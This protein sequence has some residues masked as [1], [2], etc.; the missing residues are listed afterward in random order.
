ME[1][2]SLKAVILSGGSGTRL[3]PITYSVPK[4]LIPVGLRPVLGHVLA[5]VAASGIEEAIVIVSP[6][7][8]DHVSGLL[9]RDDHGLE[10]TIVVQEEPNGLAAA[11]A[12]ALPLIGDS[13]SLLYLGDCLVT[14]GASNLVAQHR[15]GGA[16]ATLMV[17]SVDDPSRYGI[18]EIDTEGDIT[19]LV[20][21]PHDPPSDLA[22]VG[23]YAFSP[24]IA[25]AVRS[26]TPSGRGEYEITDAIHH[27]VEK[28][29]RVRPAPLEGWWI[30]TGT[31]ADVL[32][33]NS[34]LMADMETRQEGE[35]V[36]SD[37]TAKVVIEAGAV[38]RR[39]R[40]T[41]SMV[42]RS[43]AIVEDSELGAST[44]IAEG[45]EV[46]RSRVSNSIIMDGASVTDVGLI[47]SIIG[48][49]SAIDGR[50]RD[51]ELEVVVGSE[52]RVFSP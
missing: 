13:D 37:I 39:S 50:G 35:V 20:E 44:H 2:P 9:E 6:E 3:R 42:I 28:G 29:G 8:S 11:Y 15:A 12:L 16:D 25:D 7:S 5:D 19:R 26:I 21:K 10:T 17:T 23:I 24:S 1:S 34:R 49:Q 47:D 38:V 41:G 46:R 43:G 32:S 4:Q 33:A 30:D 40:L 51:H 18:V 52:A 48:P 22:I 27:L 45:A 36:D 31:V 14:G